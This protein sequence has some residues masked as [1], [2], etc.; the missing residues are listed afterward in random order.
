MTTRRDVNLGIVSALGAVAAASVS[1]AQGTQTIDLPPPA[2]DGGKTLMQSLKERRSTREYS[3]R[4]VPSQ[5]LSN[6]L[7]A[8]WGVNRP[9]TDGRTAPHWHNVYAMDIYVTR[10]DGVWLYQPKGQRLAFHMQGDLRA[11]TT[12]GQAFAA[13]AP[14]NLVYACDL[15]K[16]VPA[17]EGEKL[18]AAAACAAVVAQNV[19]LYCASDGLATVI[20]QSV[21]GERLAK[22][23][24]LPAGWIIQ[25]AQTVGY[26]KT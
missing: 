26:P 1:R 2:I 14:L 18:I 10:A 22:A 7:W 12:T 20:R 17:S 16:L 21:P 3:D 11:Q 25:F 5:V 4:D 23:L 9:Q 6:L 13:T 24:G 15:S 19:Y 8:A